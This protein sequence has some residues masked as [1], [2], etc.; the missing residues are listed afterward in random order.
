MEEL[1]NMDSTAVPEQHNT[2]PYADLA[3]KYGWK[4]EKGDKSSR[5]FIEYAMENLEPRGRE[6]KE[7]KQTLSELKAHME[8]QRKQG[9]AQAMADLENQKR[10]A[11]AAGDVEAADK[12]YNEL[13]KI[14]QPHNQQTDERAQEMFAQKHASLIADDSLEAFEI[15][16]FLHARHQNLSTY[17]LDPD[18]K[19]QRLEDEM[20]RKFPAYFGV[21][22]VTNPVAA[23]KV[24]TSQA[25][26][27][28]SFGY[29]DLSK[30]QREI[31]DFMKFQGVP[32]EKY[33]EGLVKEGM[34]K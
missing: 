14:Q 33:I 3:Q 30:E 23:E 22:T 6:L 7:V 12:V 15:K 1:L 9:Y 31:A 20:M 17:N 5:E 8:E 10:A 24:P 32:V 13:R 27:K 11:I 21:N 28:K 4:P 25:V 16:N 2:D 26:G 18:T 29:A 34:L 19:F